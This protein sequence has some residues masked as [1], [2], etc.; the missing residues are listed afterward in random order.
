MSSDTAIPVSAEEC[1][2]DLV[3]A[4][5]SMAFDYGQEDDPELWWSTFIPHFVSC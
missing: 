2:Y 5:L 1:A 4:M 3:T